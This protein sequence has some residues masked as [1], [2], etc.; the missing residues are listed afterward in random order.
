MNYNKD[1]YLILGV[2]P[3][4]EDVVI[5]A[6]YK[7]LIQRYHPDR[8]S[9]DNE[10]AKAKTVELNEAY[11]VLSNPAKRQE[12]DRQRSKEKSQAYETDEPE[13]SKASDS[14]D[15]EWAL[16]VEYYP[17]LVVIETRLR[18][19][20]ARLAVSYRQYLLSTK[21][22]EQR[23]QIAQKSEKYFLEAYFGKN[24]SIVS[25]AK[26][27]IMDG[28]QEGA[29]ELNRVVSVIGTS[30]ANDVI[31]KLT[32]KY[33]PVR[34][35]KERSH[36]RVETPEEKLRREMSEKIDAEE[37]ERARNAVDKTAWFVQLLFIIPFVIFAV[38]IWLAAF[39]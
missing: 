3:D 14:Q 7:A 39:N 10:Y 1:Y 11:E 23:H 34:E 27:L 33:Y 8:Y 29:R 36:E 28:K 38:A 19:I 22:F 21:Q 25:F 20:A 15:G 37:N 16:A 24:P 31:A 5:K 35:P 9:G 4:T 13:Q 30:N 2:T 26:R 32:Q 12:Y 17:D 6:A 18:K